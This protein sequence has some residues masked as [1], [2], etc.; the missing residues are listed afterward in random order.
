MYTSTGQAQVTGCIDNTDHV[1]ELH[2]H[3]ACM[4]ACRTGSR[5]RDAGVR[6]VL[7]IVSKKIW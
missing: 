3:R 4:P 7:K 2:F 6:E 1:S 5:K